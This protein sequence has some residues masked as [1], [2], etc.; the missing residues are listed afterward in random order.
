MIVLDTSVVSLL[1][2]GDPRRGFYL[3]HMTD[4]RTVISF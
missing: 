4:E 2:R 3:G 1:F